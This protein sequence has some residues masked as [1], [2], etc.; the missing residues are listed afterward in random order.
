MVS[1]AVAGKNWHTV[2]PVM[3][4]VKR[5]V[6]RKGHHFFREERLQL[7]IP[8]LFSSSKSGNSRLSRTTTTTPFTTII[9]RRL[10]VVLW[11][12]L[13]KIFPVNTQREQVHNYAFKEEREWGVEC[14]WSKFWTGSGKCSF[15]RLI[16]LKNGS[17]ERVHEQTNQL[18]SG[19]AVCV[20]IDLLPRRRHQTS[21]NIVVTSTLAPCNAHLEKRLL[22]KAPDCNPYLALYLI[23]CLR[24]V[25]WYSRL[26]PFNYVSAHYAL[27]TLFY[28]RL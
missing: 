3:Q 19:C 4:E 5:L 7:T 10:Q 2:P 26:I 24:I 1:L 13:F 8:S 23:G 21:P 20:W 18:T 14:P 16:S 11:A 15:L 28:L 27:L 17:V 25:Q 9:R 6:N 22:Q 12:L